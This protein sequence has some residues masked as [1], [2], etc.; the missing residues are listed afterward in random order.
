MQRVV[1][2]STMATLCGDQR[3]ANPDH[4]WT[5]EDWND[6][7]GSAYSKAKTLSERGKISRFPTRRL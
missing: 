4:V 6:N 7:P 5:E 3:T 1:I 2:T